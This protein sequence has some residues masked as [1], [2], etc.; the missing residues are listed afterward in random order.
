MKRRRFPLGIALAATIGAASPLAACAFN[1]FGDESNSSSGGGDLTTTFASSEG[2][3]SG[4]GGGLVHDGSVDVVLSGDDPP[5]F[6]GNSY[7]ELCGGKVD[8]ASC[9]HLGCDTKNGGC[10]D[11]GPTPNGMGCKL[12]SVDGG[13]GADAVCSESG[14][15]GIDAVCSTSADCGPGLGCVAKGQACRAYCCEDT[16]ACPTGTWCVPEHLNDADQKV[17]VCVQA[18]NCS[19]LDDISRPCPNNLMCTIVRNDGTTACVEPGTGKDGDHCACAPGYVCSQLADK[20]FKLC[21]T[22]S[23]ADCPD[24]EQC[25]GGMG[26]Y[27]L[28]IGNCV[29]GQ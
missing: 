23:N 6:T 20:C 29:G 17:P 4:T 22:G 3:A 12:L 13:D 25:V 18:D 14:D 21:H 5:P 11:A 15:A 19:L 9:N 16:E 10:S 8:G 1:G 24:G 7:C 26:G 27:P 28:N 2:G